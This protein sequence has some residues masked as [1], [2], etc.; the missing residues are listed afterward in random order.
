MSQLEEALAKARFVLLGEIHANSDHHLIQ[1]LLVEA[2]VK[3]GGRRPAVVFEMISPDQQA[4]LDR[5]AKDV[6]LFAA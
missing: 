4:D 6:A 5:H 3:K 2:L 1:A